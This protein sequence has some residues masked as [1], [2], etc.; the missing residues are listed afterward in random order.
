MA[1]RFVARYTVDGIER[2]VVFDK[3]TTS[4]EQ[5]TKLLTD[6][7][8]KNFMFFFE[9]TEPTAFGKNDM[10]F[11]G[12]VGF[13]I[14]AEA[15][16]PFVNDGKGIVLD[17]AGGSLWEAWKIYDTIKLSGKN[18]SIGV[19]GV[20]ASA[21]TVILL[22]S[23]N[24]WASENSR[25]L[26]HNPWN[27]AEG[28]DSIMFATGTHLKN[29]K[30][31]LAEKYAEIS[32]KPIDEML[33]LMKE[34]RWL[35]PTEM[36]ELNF[37]SS[38]KTNQKKEEDM[39]AKEVS[40]K[41]TV[42]EGLLNKVMNLIKPP[43]PKNITLTD[44]NGGII[45]FPDVEDESTVTVGDTATI[46]GKPAVGEYVIQG[47]MHDGKTF[48]FEAGK[49]AEIKEPAAAPDEELEALKVAN[50]ELN[51]KLTEAIQNNATLASQIKTLG[52]KFAEIKNVVTTGGEPGSNTPPA[53]KPTENIRKPFKN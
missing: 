52:E 7:G 28:D 38:I 10:V 43:E 36:L 13:D 33:S 16:M 29:E 11:K 4:E 14:T 22:A 23:E 39:D 21:A 18:P 8:V 32:G 26:I 24:R 9:P 37:I 50:T 45:D 31:K 17:S 12:E 5:A 19:V 3:G 44:A 27:Y 47:G 25:G 49:L 1:Q 42:F 51:N 30:E 35:T 46:D 40:E 48:V 6:Q 34:E 41:L 20:C 15:V 2:G 53:G